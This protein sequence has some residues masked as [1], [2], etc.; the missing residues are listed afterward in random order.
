MGQEDI[1]Y[2]KQ[3]AVRILQQIRIK[4][5]SRYCSKSLHEK[6]FSSHCK[7][8]ATAQLYSDRIA[9]NGSTREEQFKLSKESIKE[10][11]RAH[12]GTDS[13]AGLRWQRVADQS[14]RFFFKMASN[15]VDASIER[16]HWAP[17]SQALN[18]FQGW[19]TPRHVF[20]PVFVSLFVRDV[21]DL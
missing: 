2:A 7:R 17:S 10:M 6:G 14:A 21:A 20:K 13:E 9:L 3:P 11:P 19:L 8:R 15:Q 5:V 1:G 16:D 12:S 4:T 18:L